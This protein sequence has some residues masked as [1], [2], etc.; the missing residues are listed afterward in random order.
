MHPLKRPFLPGKCCFNLDSHCLAWRQY[1]QARFREGSVMQSDKQQPVQYS[2]TML[3]LMEAFADAALQDVFDALAMQDQ[4]DGG[5]SIL[6]RCAGSEALE[7]HSP[8]Q[9]TID[10]YITPR[11]YREVLEHIGGDV[12][13][14]VQAVGKEFVI[15]HL[16]RFSQCCRIEGIIPPQHS[17]GAWIQCS[18]RPTKQFAQDFEVS[19]KS[20]SAAVQ[21][22]QAL[23][24]KGVSNTMS[25]S[26]SPRK[27]NIRPHTDAML[28]RFGLDDKV[29]LKLHE[30]ISSICSSHWE[31]ALRSPKWD[32]TYE[33]AANLSKALHSDLDSS[34]LMFVGAKVWYN[35]Q[36]NSSLSPSQYRCASVSRHNLPIAPES[37]S[38][39]RL[40]LPL[41][42]R[43]HDNSRHFKLALQ[44]SWNG[45][46]ETV[47]TIASSHHKSFHHVQNDL[48]IGRGM[49]RF[50]HSKLSAWNAFCWKKYQENKANSVMGK[51]ILRE[52]VKD[53]H[54]EY[55]DL[56]KAEKSQL[57]LKYGEYKET[58]TSGTLKAIES[59]L[60]NLKSHTG[61]EAMLYA[62]PGSTDLPLCGIAFATEGIA[63]QGMKDWT[64]IKV[65]IPCMH[66]EEECLTATFYRPVILFANGRIMGSSW[67]HQHILERRGRCLY[68]EGGCCW[69]LLVVVGG[70]GQEQGAWEC[71]LPQFGKLGV[72]AA[73]AAVKCA[74][75]ECLTGQEFKFGVTDFKPVYDSFSD[76]IDTQIVL[77]Q[78]LLARWKEYTLRILATL[79]DISL[80][81]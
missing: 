32:L 70:G 21:M 15:P 3:T 68:G 47:K 53:H 38:V 20:V 55:Q 60:N 2:D 8:E 17:T 58:K 80:L 45:L 50:K 42:F 39:R 36:V 22:G 9:Y 48:C 10:L 13:A 66:V 35:I 23:A 72:L 37:L 71:Y 56:T 76:Y 14:L 78:E 75:Q 4:L 73:S 43:R 61:T 67:R 27:D 62:T 69:W 6:M 31:V 24:K 29:L 44:D 79:R 52:I 63:V 81:G 19:D 34:Q 57:L 25:V 46:D 7:S 74:L 54:E 1:T 28:D 5:I 41:Q 59:K 51:D 18:P 65:T 16:Q 12:S 30:L 64:G 40:V 33:Q 77:Y 26:A 11:E 49:M